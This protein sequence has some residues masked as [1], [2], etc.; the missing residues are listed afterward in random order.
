MSGIK[1]IIFDLGGVLLNIDY[2]KTK[3][4]FLDLGYTDFEKMYSLSKANNFFDDLE[5]GHIS[6]AGFY[7]YMVGAGEGKIT[8]DEIRDAWNAM[9]LDFRGESLAFLKELMQH[10][11]KIFLLSNTNSIHK[12]A[13]DESLKTQTGHDS[14]DSF[15]TK[16]YYSCQLGM[17]KPNED[18]FRFVLQDAGIKPSETLFIDDLYGNIE[19]ANKLGIQT[20]LLVPGERIEA[21]DYN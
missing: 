5:T 8:K 11:K 10:N 19:T 2:S 4:A 21:L 18:I 16:A 20:H 1:N 12:I 13:F 15:F 3:N 9:L 7:E 14:L 6:E 17:R